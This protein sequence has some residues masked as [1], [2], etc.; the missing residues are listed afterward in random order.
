MPRMTRHQPQ[1][2]AINKFKDLCLLQDKSILWPDQ[3]IWT[4][5]NLQQWKKHVVDRPNLED[6]SFKAKLELQLADAPPILWGLAADLHYVYYLPSASI[7]QATRLENINW[8]VQKSGLVMPPEADPVWI[9]QKD[10]FSH[11][12]QKYH[13]RYAQIQLLALFALNLKE[14]GQANQILSDASKTQSILDGILEATPVRGDRA[15]DF[16]HAFLYLLFPDQ[17]EPII[18]T[19]AKEKIDSHYSDLVSSRLPDIDARLLQIRQ[20]LVNTRHLA[21]DFHFYGEIKQEWDPGEVITPTPNVREIRETAPNLELTSNTRIVSDAL[22]LLEHF[23]NIILYGPPGTGKTYWAKEIANRLVAPQLEQPQSRGAFL[24]TTIQ[25]LSFYDVIAL[26]IAISGLDQK[27]TVPQMIKMELI[28]TRLKQNP[29]KAPNNQMWG[30][31]QSHTSP[32]S[33]TVNMTL[34]SEPYIFDKTTN[35]EWYLT[36]S[37]KEYVSE[38]LSDRIKTIKQGPPASNKPED[39]IRW[40]TFHQS[41]AY[42]DFVEGLRPITD[43][44]DTAAL[45]FEMKPGVFRNLCAR[46]KDDPNNKYV[47]VIDE[48]NRGNIAKIFGEL[49][50]LIEYDKR[51]VLSIELPYSKEDFHVP[52]NLMIIGTMNTA[53][54][55]IALLDVALRRRFAFLEMLPEAELLD[56]INITLAEEDVLNIG[57]FLRNLN[58]RIV[59][60]R[61]SD[62]QIGHSYFLLL[63]EVPGDSD[64]LA[65]LDDIWN[66]QII[67]LLKEYFYGQADVFHKVL[68]SFFEQE[69]LSQPLLSKGPAVLHGEDLVAA[70][71]KLRE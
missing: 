2:E 22:R 65:C 35:A 52:S 25:D 55:S 33:K 29:V 58:Q 26:Q 24:Q 21:P 15:Y 17:Y 23:K 14:S 12:S 36:P 18:S 61:G 49:M 43:Q 71:N 70:L 4:L 67:P 20:K 57:E 1:Y 6:L 47:L 41:Y 51:G 42:E 30:Y 38:A 59:E 54:R 66:Y 3:P 68:P 28:Q 39:F 62:Y 13:F 63:K 8:A 37:G 7:R 19:S 32:E 34:R 31:L 60:L 27:Y 46:A 16:R 50:T 53:D 5:L 48:I 45:A 69:D 10:G 64:R 40:V 9:P 44:G 56:Q 11:T